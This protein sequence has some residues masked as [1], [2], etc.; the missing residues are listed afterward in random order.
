MFFHSQ[1]ED[2]NGVVSRLCH[3]FPF[4]PESVF[5]ETLPDVTEMQPG[6]DV[7]HFFT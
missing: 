3:S 1:D 7:C 2:S 4:P 5:V 6:Q